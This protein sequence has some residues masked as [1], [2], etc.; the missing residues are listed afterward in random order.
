MRLKIS[1]LLSTSL[2]RG[3]Y[4]GTKTQRAKCSGVKKN[5]SISSHLALDALKRQEL[6][7]SRRWHHYSNAEEFD[8]LQ[9][10]L[11]MLLCEATRE[12]QN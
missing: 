4:I 7:S 10:S 2:K 5:D 9:G 12:P 1:E 11:C 6:V 3:K 8:N